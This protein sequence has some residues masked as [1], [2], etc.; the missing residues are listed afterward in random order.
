V[1]LKKEWVITQEAFDRLLAALDADREEAARKYE[2]VRRKLVKFFAWRGAAQPD[3]EADETINRVARK[4]AEGAEVYNLEAYF[5]GV[6]RLVLAEEF[7]AREREQE[8]LG[9]APAPEAEGL[10]DDADAAARR[11]CLD[12][13]LGLLPGESRELIIEYYQEERGRKIERRKRLAA[14]LGIE[15]NALRIRAHRIR[16][17]LEACARACVAER[18]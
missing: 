4:L 14:R 9:R 5:Y 3:R 17:G 13:C 1:S 2:R 7:K 16:V 11:A 10:E 18:A 15:I 6:A 12:R 8:A